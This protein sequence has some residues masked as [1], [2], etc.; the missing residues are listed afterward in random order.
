M[1]RRLPGSFL[2]K[3]QCAKAQSWGGFGREGLENL[4]VLAAGLRDPAKAIQAIDRLIVGK[5]TQLRLMA[6]NGAQLL[7]HLSGDIFNT[8][9]FDKRSPNFVAPQ[10]RIGN[11]TGGESGAH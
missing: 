3:P 7:R 5:I 8:I 4:S 11:P 6:A 2:Q 10:N 1:S 9:Q